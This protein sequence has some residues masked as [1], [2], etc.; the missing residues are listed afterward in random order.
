VPGDDQ[1][2]R[3]F[4]YAVVLVETGDREAAATVLKRC[5]P[6]IRR[7]DYVKKYEAKILGGTPAR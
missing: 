3:Q 1:P 6:H 7:T 5:L 2:L 4:Y